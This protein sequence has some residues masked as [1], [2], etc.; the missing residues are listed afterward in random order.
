[1]IRHMKKAWNRYHVVKNSHKIRTAL[2]TRKISGSEKL[3][4][5]LTPHFVKNELNDAS[6]E[7]LKDNVSLLACIDIF[8][9]EYD[10]ETVVPEQTQKDIPPSEDEAVDNTQS[11]DEIQTIQGLVTQGTVLRTLEEGLAD[12][13]D[14]D[15]VPE[16]DE[17]LEQRK[18]FE[19]TLYDEPS[20]DDDRMSIE[21]EEDDHTTD[22]RKNGLFFPE[23][24]RQSFRESPASQTKQTEKKPKT[25][26][27]FGNDFPRTDNKIEFKRTVSSIKAGPKNVKRH[28]RDFQVRGREKQPLLKDDRLSKLRGEFKRKESDNERH[29]LSLSKVDPKD[30]RIIEKLQ[31]EEQSEDLSVKLPKELSNESLLLADNPERIS[32]DKKIRF[33]NDVLIKRI[34]AGKKCSSQEERSRFSTPSGMNEY[35]RKPKKDNRFSFDSFRLLN[36]DFNKMRNETFK[37]TDFKKE[38]DAELTFNRIDINSPLKERYFYDER[39]KQNQRPE[40][41]YDYRFDDREN[42]NRFEPEGPKFNRTYDF[43]ENK[44]NTKTRFEESASN[45]DTES[46]ETNRFCLSE[47]RNNYSEPFE[48]QRKEDTFSRMI[49]S[50]QKP[51]QRTDTLNVNIAERMSCE[52]DYESHN[53]FAFWESDRYE[54]K[55]NN[56]MV[57]RKAGKDLERD[58]GT[59]SM[60]NRERNNRWEL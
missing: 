29:R 50:D 10:D 7:P 60:D 14:M 38:F 8:S 3:N 20:K 31:L 35:E 18:E 24:D 23:K 53:T 11:E 30:D 56:N 58:S 42:D 51:F 2:R 46:Y 12:L 25:D 34:A 39:D 32:N 40:D 47:S 48:D 16:P 43:V 45:P 33:D 19:E 59:L 1:M 4:D 6:Q 36:A 9:E 21:Q 49:N 28:D 22:N 52:P 37:T 15:Y 17:F 55:K 54:I 13:M 27:L 57:F 44:H 41:R 5:L 26:R